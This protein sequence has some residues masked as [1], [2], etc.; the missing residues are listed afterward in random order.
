MEATANRSDPFLQLFANNYHPRRSP[1]IMLQMQPGIL[2]FADHGTSHGSPYP[3]DT[4]VP[5]LLM[6]P[7]YGPGR[8]TEKIRT[9][10]VAPTLATLA[11]VPMPAGMDGRSQVERM[12]YFR[13]VPT[14][15][16]GAAPQSSPPS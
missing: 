11:G 4:H 12:Q 1:D 3:Y 5:V 7:G 9:I 10:D 8:V 2:P 14:R 15:G 6:A 13:A 16:E